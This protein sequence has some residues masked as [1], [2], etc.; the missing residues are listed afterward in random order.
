MYIVIAAFL[1]ITQ[2]KLGKPLAVMF[3]GIYVMSTNWAAILA[4]T[5]KLDN[6]AEIGQPRRVAPTVIYW[7]LMCCVYKKML[8]CFGEKPKRRQ[9]FSKK[10][11]QRALAPAVVFFVDGCS[12]RST[13]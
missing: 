4:T 13:F 9:V 2:K 6:H 5:Q 11:R 1:M 3:L 8:P 7:Y 12:R 10:T